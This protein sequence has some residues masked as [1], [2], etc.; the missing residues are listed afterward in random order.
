M[1]SI[2]I[3]DTAMCAY[4]KVWQERKYLA[5]MALVP[6]LIKYVFF[7][8]AIT[9][10]EPGNVIRMGLIML[11]AFFAEGWFLA[12][13]VRTVI[14]GHRWPF[15]PSG[16][17][18]KD[19]SRLNQRAQGVIRGMTAF[20][21]INFLMAGYF[22]FFMH[23]LPADL[24]ISEEAAQEADPN[25]AVIGLVMAVSMFFLFRYVWGY[26]PLALNI[27]LR[28]FIRAVQP[29]RVT[30]IFIGVWLMCFV[31][32][33]LILQGMTLSFLSALGEGGVNGFLQGGIIFFR[34]VL[35]MIKN[36]LCTAGLAYA[37]VA[38]LGIKTTGEKQ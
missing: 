37:V 7:A 35:D 26:I 32:T 5:R 12:H 19:M 30:F 25:I 15:R 2:D 8:I 14:V 9:Y 6:L 22:A 17:M 11:P 34:V 29:I 38:L 18:E 3:V 36:L 1:I 31:P 20:V 13:W 23:F 10:V 27:P 21:V 33:I 16:D 28:G 24:L 4:Q